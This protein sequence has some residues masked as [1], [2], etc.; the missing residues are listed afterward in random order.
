MRERERGDK[1]HP[2]RDTQTRTSS[3]TVELLGQGTAR[4]GKARQ[5]KARQGKARQGKTDMIR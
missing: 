2:T 3:Q 1:R 5:G 4:Q